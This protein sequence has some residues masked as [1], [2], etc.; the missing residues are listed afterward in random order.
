MCGAR[1]D[2]VAYAGY[3]AAAEMSGLNAS[4][5]DGKILSEQAARYRAMIDDRWW[6]SANGRYHTFYTESGE[7]A[8]GEGIP[9]ALWFGIVQDADR[10]AHCFRT[11]LSHDWNIENLSYFPAMLIDEGYIADGYRLI[12]EMPGKN[13]SEYPEVSFA[14]VEAIVRSSMGL[15]PEVVGRTLTTE[16]RLE[17]DATEMTVENVPMFDGTVDVAHRGCYGSTLRNNTASSITWIPVSRGKRYTSVE[18]KPG[19]TAEV[20]F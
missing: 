6:D 18:V 3:M 11:I 7:F 9:F 2:G 1:S 20:N 17:D 15:A 13:R 4:L 19:E 5:P 12:K 16:Y 14:L 10:K 8:Y